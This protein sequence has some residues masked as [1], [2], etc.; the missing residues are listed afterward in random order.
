MYLFVYC[1]CDICVCV[2]D[3]IVFLMDYW[4]VDGVG[5]DIVLICILYGCD[6]IGGVVFFLVECGYYVVV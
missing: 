2:S 3:G 1:I 4:Y 5:G 6:G